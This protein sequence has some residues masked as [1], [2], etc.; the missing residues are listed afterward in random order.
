VLVGVLVA[1]LAFRRDGAPLAVA[2]GTGSAT[3]P[4]GASARPGLSEEERHKKLLARAAAGDEG[5]IAEVEALPEKRV[6][7]SLAVAQGRCARKEMVACVA[8]YKAAV[9]R[10]TR[11]RT[12]RALLPDVRRAAEH[13]IAYEEA[14]RLAAHH[15]GEGG[16]DVLWDVWTSTK[17]NPEL[18][19]INRRARAFLDDGAVRSH[20]SPAL[21][22]V[23]ELERAERRRRCKEAERLLATVVEHG[24]QRVLPVLDRFS[25]TRGCGLLDL[26]DCWGCLRG[27]TA[28]ALARDAAKDRA[29]PTF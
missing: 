6:E 19:A 20:A 11:L 3:A 29:G 28:L 2:S 8:A 15:L 13:P 25:S 21:G 14:M 26:G 5:A 16:L 27:T 18:A 22:V 4:P 9:M 17:K 24:D 23:L 1:L 7:E 12:D 10:F